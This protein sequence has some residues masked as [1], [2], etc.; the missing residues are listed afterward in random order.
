MNK[1]YQASIIIIY[2]QKQGPHTNACLL[3]AVPFL[4]PSVS[5]LPAKVHPGHLSPL[6]D[7]HGQTSP[8][9]MIQLRILTVQRAVAKLTQCLL[10][11]QLSTELIKKN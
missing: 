4:A 8:Q 7:C 10:Y 5:T 2:I 9:D 3:S 6:V 1:M 11:G